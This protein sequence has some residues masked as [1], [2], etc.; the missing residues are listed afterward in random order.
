MTGNILPTIV[1]F[2]EDSEQGCIL[3]AFPFIEA[4]GNKLK[5]LLNK[6]KNLM[7]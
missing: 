2:A 7:K 6:I 4:Q 5:T 3:R 1:S